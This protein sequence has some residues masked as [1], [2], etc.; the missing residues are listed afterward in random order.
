MSNY[1]TKLYIEGEERILSKLRIE[2]A[3][4]ESLV[5]K[6][7]ERFSAEWRQNANRIIT[8]NYEPV[9]EKFWIISH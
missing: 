5:I 1:K 4:S 8:G 3:L 2:Y 6:L 9:M 7:V